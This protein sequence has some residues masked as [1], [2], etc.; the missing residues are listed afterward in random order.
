ME[1]GRFDGGCIN[2]FNNWKD[3]DGQGCD[4]YAENYAAFRNDLAATALLGHDG[5]DAHDVCCTF[6]GGRDPRNG[7]TTVGVQP[8]AAPAADPTCQMYGVGDDPSC[9][10]CSMQETM[11]AVSQLP[12]D[13]QIFFGDALGSAEKALAMDIA[14]AYPCYLQH[15]MPAAI[16][17]CYPFPGTYPLKF[18]YSLLYICAH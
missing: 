3:T 12:V 16:P 15:T 4:H 6:G 5:Y 13:C 8:T 18:A 17:Q 1:K 14:T 10:A 9:H 11:R 2:L 7:D